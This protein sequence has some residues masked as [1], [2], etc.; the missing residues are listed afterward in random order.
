MA[1]NLSAVIPFIHINRPFAIGAIDNQGP[2]KPPVKPPIALMCI[3]TYASYSTVILRARARLFLHQ[4]QIA[5]YHSCANTFLDLHI[6]PRS[7]I[8]KLAHALML[9]QARSIRIYVRAGRPFLAV[10]IKVVADNKDGDF[11]PVVPTVGQRRR[12]HVS[13]VG[14]YSILSAPST[15]LA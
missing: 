14:R 7:L 3:N 5:L 15:H 6:L 13:N 9:S 2:L 8:Q 1:N 12:G 10:L 4:S 11:I